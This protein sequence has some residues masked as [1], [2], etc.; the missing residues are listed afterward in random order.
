MFKA[1]Q[2][3]EAVIGG[4]AQS[5]KIAEGYRKNQKQICVEPVGNK[6][7]GS[8]SFAPCAYINQSEITAE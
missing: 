7:E 5:V 3:V 8:L 4:T 1:G 2:V 6:F